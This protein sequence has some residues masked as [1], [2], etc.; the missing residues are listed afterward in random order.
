MRLV[1]QETGCFVQVKD[2]VVGQAMRT[3][4]IA[5][6][7][8]AK[9]K[10]AYDRILSHRDMYCGPIGKW[11][12]PAHTGQTGVLPRKRAAEGELDAQPTPKAAKPATSND[13]GS[14]PVDI[15]SEVE[16]LKSRV[17]ALEAQ[18]KA[19]LALQSQTMG[20]GDQSGQ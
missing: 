4:V 12:W 7:D 3:V 1:Q 8:P 18:V 20:S 5:H 15:E 19:L 13:K 10:A 9:R 2:P 14:G 16:A 6:R 17:E 11:A